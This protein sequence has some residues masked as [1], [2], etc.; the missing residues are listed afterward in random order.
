MGAA[1]HATLRVLFAP[2]M[3]LGFNGAAVAVAA[4]RLGLFWLAPLLA[5]AILFAALVEQVI[6]Y[7][8]A[9]NGSRG[10]LGRDLG[11]A[12]VNQAINITA[13]ASIPLFAFLHPWPSLWPG[14]W[15][16]WIQVLMAVVVADAGITLAHYA[17]HR[18]G[19]LWPIHAVHHSLARLY[20]FNG[21][22][23]H[24]LHQAIEIGAGGAVLV[25]FG[26]PPLVGLLLAFAVAI[27]LL[28]QHSNAD[29]RIGPFA[30]LLAVA[31]VHRHHHRRTDGLGVNFGL[32]TNLWDHLLGTA[33]VAA[34]ARVGAG[35]VGLVDRPDYPRTYV[36]QLVE[37]FARDTAPP[38]AAS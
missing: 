4:T 16:L 24:P 22:M 18:L 10:D 21:L 38:E 36:A 29:M 35:E 32:F 23:K 33:D 12:L 15:P 31:T 34:A 1:V 7:E 11:H 14:S 27:Q 37:P 2:I 20:A 26:M 13:V 6:P 19:W 5:A 17:S 8:A 9:W 25:L 30:W 3:L 28:L